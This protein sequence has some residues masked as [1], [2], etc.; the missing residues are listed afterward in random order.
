MSIGL[1]TRGYL[2]RSLGLA[3][4]GYSFS[5]P[6]DVA[7]P[8]IGT[9][10]GLPIGLATRG[11]LARSLGLGTRGYE[12]APS[13]TSSVAYGEAIITFE[14]LRCVAA[15]T[16]ADFQGSGHAVPLMRAVQSVRLSA[17][18]VGE[19]RVRA[20]VMSTIRMSATIIEEE[21]KAA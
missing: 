3:T 12:I 8:S 2:S 13:E 7:E 5:S 1:A 21:D 20:R 11:Y 18:I 14:D 17:T 16:Q 15:T 19:I 9:Q 4:H 10:G 6:E